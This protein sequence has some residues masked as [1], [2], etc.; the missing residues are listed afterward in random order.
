MCVICYFLGT[1]VFF[2]FLLKESYLVLTFAACITKIGTM[3][4][5]AWP[6]C[7]DDM[8][9]CEAFHNFLYIFDSVGNCLF[10]I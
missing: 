4:K 10:P 7:K 8:H 1:F 2:F 3:Q 6:L 9:I 5:L